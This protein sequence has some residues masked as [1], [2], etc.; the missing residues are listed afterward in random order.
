MGKLFRSEQEITRNLT[1]PLFEDK[2]PSNGTILPFHSGRRTGDSFLSTELKKL[3]GATAAV[4]GPN[5]AAKV[6]NVPHSTAS[7]LRDGITSNV[8]GNKKIDEDLKSHVEERRN[9]ISRRAVDLLFDTLG[10]VQQEEIN[11]LTV[12]ERLAAAKDMASIVEK[13]VP[14]EQ[15]ASP[16]T[17]VVFAPSMLS[18]DK[19]ELLLP[20]GA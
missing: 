16:G 12:K 1:G 3:I 17:V 10:S 11:A 5:V 8:N 13:T 6:F 15:V 7:Q 20:E 2:E 18:V 19:F 14:K 9:G 4:S